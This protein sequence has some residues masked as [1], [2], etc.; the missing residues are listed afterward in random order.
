MA[1]NVR[2]CP[3]VRVLLD[4]S[5]HVPPGDLSMLMA[6]SRCYG[7]KPKATC[8][9]HVASA[10]TSELT[11]QSR[12]RRLRQSNLAEGRQK[13]GLMTVIVDRKRRKVENER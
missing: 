7:V 4:D 6:D 1:V 8:S 9:R 12:D 5:R 2:A 3:C 13:S 10:R 11:L